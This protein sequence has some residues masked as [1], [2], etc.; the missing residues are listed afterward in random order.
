MASVSTKSMCPWHEPMEKIEAV[1]A[2]TREWLQRNGADIHPSCY[3][4]GAPLIT[5]SSSSGTVDPSGFRGCITMAEGS[6]MH[7]T[8]DNP[9]HKEFCR[10]SILHKPYSQGRLT[11]G[12][13]VN[14]NGTCIVA[15][16]PVVIEDDV[17]LGPS[18]TIMT[19]DGHSIDRSVPDA[20]CEF[21]CRPVT[22]KRRAWL[23]MGCLIMKGV[24]VGEYAVVAAGSVVT[25]DV[26]PHSIVAGNPAR[27]I[28]VIKPQGRL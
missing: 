25:R 3:F 28:K 26:Q 15:A 24:T 17:L 16:A 1:Q 8:P 27:E 5:L 6:G 4:N 12:R 10:I 22:I 7:S 11:V 9:F 20:E 2:K 19:T 13:N 23:G 14:L 18:V 21:P